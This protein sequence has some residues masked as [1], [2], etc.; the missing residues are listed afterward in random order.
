MRELIRMSITVRE[1]Y[2]KCVLVFALYAFRCIILQMYVC[3][4][5]WVCT[6]TLYTCMCVHGLARV[7]S[8]VFGPL[9]GSCGAEGEEKITGADIICFCHV[10]LA[11]D[12]THCGPV[13]HGR[14]VDVPAHMLQHDALT[15]PT[16][17]DTHMRLW[18]DDLRAYRA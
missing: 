14:Q 10:G 2:D 1:V 4:A 16:H 17:T 7:I 11:S 3:F 13:R 8:S 15:Y 5:W 12:L 18:R 6:S 9:K